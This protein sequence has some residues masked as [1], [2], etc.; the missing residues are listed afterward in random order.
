M[1][2]TIRQRKLTRTGHI[3]FSVGWLGSVACFLT[4]A[5]V[6]FTSKDAQM[7]RAAYP[8]M[9]LIAWFIIIPLSFASPL[10]GIIL[11]LGTQWGLFRHYWIL[12]KFMITIFSTIVLLIHMQPISIMADAAAKTNLSGINLH[13]LQVQLVIAP[14]AALL[15]FLVNVVLAVYKPKGMTRYGQRKLRQKR[16]MS[17]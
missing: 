3:T 1:S 15:A 17:V 4:L 8:A 7:A 13:G 14:G 11:A 6:G 12:V 2:M 16:T 9:K 5:V 10:T